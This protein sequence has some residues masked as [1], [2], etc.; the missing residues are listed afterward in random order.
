MQVVQCQ[1][2]LSR[3]EAHHAL[4]EPAQL[5]EMEEQVAASTEVG[6][7]VQPSL[8]LERVAE[9][10]HKWMLQPSRRQDGTAQSVKRFE[11]L[12]GRVNAV[13]L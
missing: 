7:C 10:E 6:Q 9:L 2:N 13:A 1:G 5:L 4:G 3:V 11:G 8:R 12:I